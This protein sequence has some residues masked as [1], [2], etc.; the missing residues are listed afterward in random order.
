[1]LLCIWHV[2]NLSAAY[3]VFAL[4]AT[5][6]KLIHPSNILVAGPTGCGKTYFVM[7][8]IMNDMFT[9]RFDRIVL[10]YSEWQPLYDDLRLYRPDT[11]FVRELNEDL[12]HSFDRTRD[13]LVILDDQM[14][15]GGSKGTT[16]NLFVQ[17]SHHRSI[18]IIYLVQNFY[19]KNKNQR[20]LSLNTQYII[21][22]KNP[23]GLSQA[24]SFGKDMF[25]T[26]GHAFVDVYK[27][28]TIEANGYLLVDNR[29]DTPDSY[30]LRSRIFPHESNDVYQLV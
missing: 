24:M 2:Y 17:G 20:T 27:D 19:E 9:T 16:T 13:N 21:L 8:L 26:K 15:S 1:M 18:T 3:L 7:K 23:R 30:R 10:V 6:N 25:P 12:Y 22:F 28:A 14:T 5:M 11:E 4:R 29:V